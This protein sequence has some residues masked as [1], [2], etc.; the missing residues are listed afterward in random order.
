MTTDNIKGKAGKIVLY[1]NP[2]F[3]YFFFN[4]F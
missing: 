4:Y 2:L 3:V 1:N